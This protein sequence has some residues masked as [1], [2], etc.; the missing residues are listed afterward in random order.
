MNSKQFDW[1]GK[2]PNVYK[3]KELEIRA[4]ANRLLERGKVELYISVENTTI[5][6]TYVINKDLIKSYFAEVKELS[7]ELGVTKTDELL[8]VILKFPEALISEK[9]DLVEDE[10]ETIIKTIEDAILSVDFFRKNEGAI[11]A[12]DFKQR[13]SLILGHLATIE[14]FEKERLEIIKERILSGLSKILDENKIDKNRMEQEL[15]YYIEKIDFTE[16]K[17]RLRKHCD[18]FID[19]MNEPSSGK[20]LGFVCQEIGREINTL[21]SKANDADIQQIVVQMKDELE[22]IKEQLMNIL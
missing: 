4:I 21:G 19:T 5:A 3:E 13:I 20:K 10:W 16:E 2:L 22:K 9:D 8:S 6:K 12:E 18:Y 14:T 17:V 1:N 15:I 11:L 7:Y